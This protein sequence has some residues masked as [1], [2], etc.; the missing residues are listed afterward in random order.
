MGIIVLGLKAH[1]IVHKM[2]SQ[3]NIYKILKFLIGCVIKYNWIKWK[4]SQNY[5][6]IYITITLYEFH[7]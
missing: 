1:Y 6:V 2:L 7:G 3:G 5:N 4:G